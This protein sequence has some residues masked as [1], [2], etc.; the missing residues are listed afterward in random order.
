[1]SLIQ[2]VNIKTPMFAGRRDPKYASTHRFLKVIR[3]RCHAPGGGVVLRNNLTRLQALIYQ[4]CCHTPKGHKLLV[5]NA[6]SSCGTVHGPSQATEDLLNQDLY[7]QSQF[8]P[9]GSH[10]V[11]WSS[12]RSPQLGGVTSSPSDEVLNN[13]DAMWGQSPWRCAMVRLT[14]GPGSGTFRSGEGHFHH[15]LGGN[16]P[17]CEQCEVPTRTCHLYL[18]FGM[19]SQLMEYI[20]SG[21]YPVRLAAYTKLHD[22]P[23]PCVV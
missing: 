5:A 22:S 11:V 16:S 20:G 23:L 15:Q 9:P 6:N 2:V 10:Q 12:T 4:A 14:T 21:Q 19:D 3:P 18:R 1:M 17:N 7:L 13:N 8:F